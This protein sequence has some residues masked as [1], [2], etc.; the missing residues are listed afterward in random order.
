MEPIR[1]EVG[2]AQQRIQDHSAILV[3]AY[4]D[5]EKFSQNHLEG[6]IS[7]QEFTDR[8]SDLSKD[9]EIIFYCA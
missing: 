5:D 4:E 6:A 7:F 1:I 9:Q 3:C 8:K 2:Q